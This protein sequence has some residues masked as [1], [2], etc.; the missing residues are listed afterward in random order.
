MK[1][2]RKENIELKIMPN[3]NVRG[4]Q[5]NTYDKR[6]VSELQYQNVNNTAF[7]IMTGIQTKIIEYME[8]DKLPEELQGKKFRVRKTTPKENFRLMDVDDE[9]IEKIQATGLSKSAQYQLAGNSIVVNVLYHIFRKLLI[10]TENE[11]Q[12]L[13]LF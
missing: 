9:Y 7:T 4:F 10:E 2:K 12:Q 11:S 8:T 5:S 13:T 3:G 6:A 1:S